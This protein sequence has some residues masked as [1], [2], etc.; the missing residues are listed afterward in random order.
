MT[1]RPFTFTRV[2]RN[3][4]LWGAFS[5]LIC[6]LAAGVHGQGPWWVAA[7][8]GVVAQVTAL[9]LLRSPVT[10]LRLDHTGLTTR[11]GRSPARHFAHDDIYSLEH[12]SE[13]AS[14]PGFL[15]VVLTDGRREAL[16]LLHLPRADVLER[17]SKAH[18]LPL[19]VY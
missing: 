7:S 17:V 6:L 16:T 18:G 13:G 3:P 14:G 2:A 19:A 5:V 15:H 9:H 10:R 8:W 11:Q 12:F 4:K 1:A